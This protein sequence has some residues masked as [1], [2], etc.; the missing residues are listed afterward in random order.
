MARSILLASTPSQ[1]LGSGFSHADGLTAHALLIEAAR[2]P[3]PQPRSRE[4]MIL[5]GLSDR[6]V[7]ALR[8]MIDGRGTLAPSFVIPETIDRPGETVAR[9]SIVGA[10]P[11]SLERLLRRV[12]QDDLPVRW[13]R[14]LESPTDW[15]TALAD[16]HRSAS[17][18]LAGIRR[19][20][21]V[22]HALEQVRYEIAMSSN[23]ELGGYLTSHP[24]ARR[25][26]AGIAMP[27][28]HDVR[29]SFSRRLTFG[30][31]SMPRGK[32]M[33]VLRDDGPRHDLD[34]TIAFGIGASAAGSVA[35]RLQWS[36]IEILLGPAR[37]AIL[38]S[39]SAPMTMGALAQA[40]NY[41]PS[42]I[43]YHVKVLTGA[44]LL[45]VRRERHHVWVSRSPRGELLIDTLL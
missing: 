23:A 32:Y 22:T 13:Q 33:I 7:T 15:L 27:W 12:Y 40:L 37:A 24:P 26:G 30:T 25:V 4:A 41:A 29:L 34:A 9:D 20:D 2:S 28:V 11:A 43:S 5:R 16:A 3:T 44:D 1:L 38:L 39:A 31:L 42:T 45:D 8:T 6:S 36:R 17:E 18:V 19:R 21:R 10:D 14:V 35:A